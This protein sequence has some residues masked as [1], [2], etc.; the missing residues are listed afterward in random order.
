MHVDRAASGQL[1]YDEAEICKLSI[2]CKN[3]RLTLL[4][5]DH[6]TA[7]EMAAVLVRN[8]IL[9][10]G[11]KP[12]TKL[13]VQHLAKRYG[14]GTTPLREALTQLAAAGL[15]M[16]TS[17]RGFQTPGLSHAWWMDLIETREILETEALRLAL[18]NRTLEWEDNVV[19]S[20]HLFVREIERLFQKETDSIQRYWYRHSEFH[21]AVIA[22]CPL[23]NLKSL[24]ST[25]YT[26]MIP[27]RRL[28]VTDKYSKN[29]LIRAHETLMN[30]ALSGSPAA[31]ATMRKHISANAEIIN[32]VLGSLESKD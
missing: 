13:K 1:L 5:Q 22:A 27:Y 10:G 30:D 21:H 17:Q 3:G 4:G 7:A 25:L 32:Q 20:F 15:V 9:E 6:V 12:N 18:E 31:I 26:R 29:K 24:V 8:E 23:K 16:Q 14:V 2:L 28:T 11:I 19:S